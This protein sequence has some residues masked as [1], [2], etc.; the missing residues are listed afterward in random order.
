VNSEPPKM[1]EGE[2]LE[3]VRLG[4]ASGASVRDLVEKTGWSV[5]WVSARRRELSQP[6][7]DGG[8]DTAEENTA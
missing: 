5:G 1:P 6:A 4:V 3:A 2:A 7:A 8:E